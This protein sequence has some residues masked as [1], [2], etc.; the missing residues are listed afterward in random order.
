M[1][2]VNV[3]I[4]IRFSMD[5][6]KICY[7][8]YFA[9]MYFHT[10]AIFLSKNFLFG[11]C[12]ENSYI[13]FLFLISFYPFVRLKVVWMF[14][15]G[16]WFFFYLSSV[17]DFFSLVRDR[18]LGLFLLGICVCAY[19]LCM[20]IFWV[21]FRLCLWLWM[22]IRVVVLTFFK[23]DIFPFTWSFW[24]LIIPFRLS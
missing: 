5:L 20:C 9:M 12:F 16:C 19:I 2:L 15:V 1:V 24:M 3:N 14:F 18:K 10:I 23:K 4:I 7:T 17:R 22:I 11:T 21:D 6:R 13:Y 8:Y